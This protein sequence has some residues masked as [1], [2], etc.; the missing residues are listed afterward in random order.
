[1]SKT[2]S[3]DFIDFFTAE[4][5]A[6]ISEAT[7]LLAEALKTDDSDDDEIAKAIT[8]GVLHTFE[9]QLGAFLRGFLIGHGGSA[10]PEE[11]HEAVIN[12]MCP[13]CISYWGEAYDQCCAAHA[14]E[15][16][17]NAAFTDSMLL[18]ETTGGASPHGDPSLN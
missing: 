3:H 10:S 8:D 16:F 15:H 13:Y 11:I 6:C 12:N 5:H 4:D 17:M 9:A 7:S 1:M 18:I 14:I 2:F